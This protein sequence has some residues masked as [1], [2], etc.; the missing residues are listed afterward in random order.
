VGPFFVLGD[1]LFRKG[2]MPLR[3]PP[4]KRFPIRRTSS[5][6]AFVSYSSKDWPVVKKLLEA[7][8][9]DRVWVDK[10]NVE[11]GDALPEKIETGIA[12]AATYILVLS[13]SS[14][15]SRWVRY[16]SHMATI[17]HLED[18][19]FRILV[20]KIDDC[21]VPLRFRPF[22]YADLASD[23]SALQS[24][25]RAAASREG[26]AA[27]YRRHFVNRSEDLGRIEAHVG[28]PDK[29]VVCLHGFYG[30]GKRTL[31]EESIRRTWQSPRITTIELSSAHHGARLSA[32]LCAAAGIPIPPDGTAGIELRRISLLAAERLVERRHVLIFDHFEHLLDDE[33]KPHED[34]LAVID[35]VA[36]LNPSFKVPCY[37]LSRRTPR[38]PVATTLRVGFVQVGG[39]DSQ[40]I[41]TILESEASRISRTNFTA[42]P[43]LRSLAEHL[44]GYPLAGRLA[45]PLVVKYPPEYLLNNLAHITSLKRDIAEAILANTGF[46]NEQERVLQILGRL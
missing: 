17:R 27:L 29:S 36:A 38:F 3:R 24:V 37:V 14:L 5:G 15:E 40:H 20:L 10:R 2:A 39:M 34:I 12:E 1:A 18:A 35:H 8:T 6:Y 23:S 21:V 11:L 43:A 22:L 9:A 44:F 32:S 33:G 25:A 13:K 28:D 19:N 26:P 42:G 16:E 45:A 41:V 4:K 7:L 46:T 30:I 31:A